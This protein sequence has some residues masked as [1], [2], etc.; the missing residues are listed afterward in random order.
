VEFTY[1]LVLLGLLALP[2]IAWWLG[3]KGPLPAITLPSLDALRGLGMPAHRRPGRMR[4]A[5]GLA[6]LALMIVA[7]AR[8]RAP[9]GEQADPT[10]GID[11]MLALDFSRSMAEHDF[12]LNGR[13]ISRREALEGV[14]KKFM[15]GRPY[16]RIGIVCFARSPFL[17]SPLT[18]DHA[19]SLESL[20]NT[21]LATGT[22]IGEGMSASLQFL[23]AHSSRSKVVILV[24][25]GQNQLGR[26][27]VLVARA[28]PENNVRLY[29]ILIGTETVTPTAA[30]DHELN[31]ASRMTG[32]QFFQ[33]NDTA[34]LQ[35]VY[36]SIDQL[37]KMALLQQRFV[38]WRELFPWPAG[39]ALAL[40]LIDFVWKQRVRFP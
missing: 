32:G 16:D 2:I 4:F 29:C 18:L 38:D 5:L 10:K 23:K 7:L 39:A 35:K 19:W 3:K 33:A 31:K 27:P 6:A 11:I 20:T 37:E 21:D 14:V 22:A 24:T 15:S 34:A 40:L 8:P 28:F 26:P 17:V 1:P 30:A 36:D 13:R 12:H 9:R 25:D